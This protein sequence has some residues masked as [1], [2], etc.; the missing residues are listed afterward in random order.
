MNC[1]LLTELFGM[2]Q[3]SHSNKFGPSRHRTSMMRPWKLSAASLWLM[4]GFPCVPRELG[5]NQYS[6]SR[7]RRIYTS[8]SSNIAAMRACGLT[9]ED[10]VKFIIPSQVYNEFRICDFVAIVAYYPEYIWFIR[11]TGRLSS[12]LYFRLQL[13]GYCYGRFV[14]IIFESLK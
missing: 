3:V 12:W 4:N 2:T 8:S 14:I 6:R 9:V 5:E 7:W 13:S 10:S 11:S 1:K